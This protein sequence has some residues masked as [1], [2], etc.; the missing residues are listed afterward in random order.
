MVRQMGSILMNREHWSSTKDD[1][2]ASAVIEQLNRICNQH[3]TI[4]EFVEMNITGIRKILKK[5]DK[6]MQEYS[7]PMSQKYLESRM[8]NAEDGQENIYSMRFKQLLSHTVLIEVYLI[9]DDCM[10][11]L[12]TIVNQKIKKI[13]AK[14][15]K[16]EITSPSDIALDDHGLGVSSQQSLWQRVLSV[17]GQ[18]ETQ[19]TPTNSPRSGPN[20]NRRRSFIEEGAL[21]SRN[22]DK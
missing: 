5:F 10:K 2:L 16:S 6:Q 14:K 4:A 17:F 9:L 7:L 19:L 8:L 21:S 1:I 12:K 15:D 22:M 3:K 11:Q 13:K 20:L 18:N